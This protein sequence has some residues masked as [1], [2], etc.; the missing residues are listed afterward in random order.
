MCG[1]QG[2]GSGSA[3]NMQVRNQEGK[4]LREKKCKEI[5]SNCNLFSKFRSFGP[6]LG[7]ISFEPSFLSFLTPENFHKVPVIFYQIFKAGSGSELKKEC[8]STAL[9]VGW[10]IDCQ[11]LRT[12]PPPSISMAAVMIAVL[13]QMAF[14]AMPS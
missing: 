10:L 4:N 5:E 6:A 14:T 3:F 12:L 7:F 1:G 8:V 13:G 11:Q 2:C 9:V